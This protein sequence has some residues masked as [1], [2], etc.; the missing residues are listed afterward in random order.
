MSS[1]KTLIKLAESQ[2]GVT[3]GERYWDYYAKHY[4]PGLGAYINGDITP[5]CACFCSWLLG[6]TDTKCPFFPSTVAF[7]WT[8]NLGGRGIGK[9]DL[10]PGDMISF[11]WDGDNGGDHVGVVVDV[12]DWGVVTVEGNT[13]GG[14]VARRNR[15]WSQI[16]CGVRPYYDSEDDEMTDADWKKLEKMLD[17][18]VDAAMKRVGWNVW[19]YK[20][21]P[22]NGDKD[23]YAL[24]TD[25]PTRV[26]GYRNKNYESMDAYRILRDIRNA[27]FPTAALK[28]DGYEAKDGVLPRIEQLINDLKDNKDN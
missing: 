20:Y 2:V 10:Q 7:D 27:L 18:K 15:Y 3:S 16:I 26:W 11:D 24:L 1:A 6:M 4:R 22:V 13:S 28:E 5:Y 21:K 9:Y 23:A 25:T 12:K 17:A 14:I 8:D 19:S